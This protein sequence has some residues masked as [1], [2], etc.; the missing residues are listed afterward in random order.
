MKSL[1]VKE[2]DQILQIVYF[3]YDEPKK[4]IKI[5]TTMSSNL[6]T[7]MV[8]IQGSN[9]YELFLLGLVSGNSQQERRFHDTFKNHWIRGEWYAYHSDIV[10][11]FDKPLHQPISAL[12][13]VPGLGLTIYE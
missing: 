5:G 9:P 6:T 1:L 4:F 8:S 13:K 2:L 11:L 3:V 12:K 7:R 10:S